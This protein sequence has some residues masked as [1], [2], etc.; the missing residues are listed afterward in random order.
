MFYNLDQVSDIT[1]SE[2]LDYLCNWKSV[3]QWKIIVFEPW[4]SCITMPMA[5]SI[6]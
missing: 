3:I 1:L 4:K 6:G 2:K 5:V